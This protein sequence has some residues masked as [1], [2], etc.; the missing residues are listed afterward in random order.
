MELLQA[1][2]GYV[3]ISI[4]VLVEE[5]QLCKELVGLNYEQV[6]CSFFN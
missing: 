3:L 6:L 4:K 2:S 1:L 5:N